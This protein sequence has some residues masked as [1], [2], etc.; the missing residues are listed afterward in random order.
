[1]PIVRIDIVEGRSEA[2]RA[3]VDDIVYPTIVDLLDV[4]EGDRFQVITEGP[5]SFLPFDHHYLGGARAED[6]IFV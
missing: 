6:F 4:P 2:Y 3:E 1:M 5:E